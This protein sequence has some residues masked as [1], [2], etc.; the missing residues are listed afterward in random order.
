MG[1]RSRLVLQALGNQ[2]VTSEEL[3]E[4]KALIRKMEEK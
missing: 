1:D 2:N 3:S 4:V